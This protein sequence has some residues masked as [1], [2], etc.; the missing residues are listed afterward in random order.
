MSLIDENT[1]LAFKAGRCF[2]REGTNTVEAN[3]AKGAIVLDRGEDELLHFYWKN[4][5]TGITDEDLILFPSDAT[6]VKVSQ[7]GDG[8][9]VYVLKF[10][11][12][13]QRHFFWMQDASA[14]KDEEFVYH[15]NNLLRLP[16]YIPVWNTATP[17]GSSSGQPEA[18]TS[19]SPSAGGVGQPTSDQLAQLRSLVSQMSTGAGASTEPELSLTDVLTPANLAPLFTSHPTLIPTLFPHLPADLPTPPSPEV[20][21]DITSSPQFR[22]AVVSLDRALR[23]GLLG[24]LVRQLGL[25]EEAGLGVE[26]FLRAVAEQGR[27]GGGEG[28]SMDTD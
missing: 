10:S 5:D 3:P 26:A 22:Q 16:G 21:R 6:F 25:P 7:A 20:L 23:T 17:S 19:T 1:I 13:N 14:E 28:E 24:G 8:G 12:S 27:E 15:L 18:S 2:R 9:R 4:R 11:S